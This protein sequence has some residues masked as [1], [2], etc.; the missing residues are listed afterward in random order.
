MPTLTHTDR[1]R[2]SS[3]RRGRANILVAG[4]G[5]LLLAD[6]GVGVHLVRALEGTTPRGVTVVDVGTAVLDALHLFEGADRVLAL[7]AMQ[8]GGAPGDIYV[9]NLD[10][11]DNPAL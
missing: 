1:K 6:D 4:L 9:F 3:R 2:A 7:D 10:D 11:A 8:A 5:N